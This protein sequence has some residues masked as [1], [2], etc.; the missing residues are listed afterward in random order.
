MFVGRK[1]EI[2]ELKDLLKKKSASFVV[3]KGRRRIGKSR[4]LDEFS[5]GKKTFKFTG[6]APHKSTTKQRQLDE[7]SKQLSAAT[8]L[9]EIKTDEWSK[10][11]ALLAREVKTGRV[12]I[13]FDE[14]S[15][16]GSK[17]PDFLGKLKNAWDEKFKKNAKLIFIVCGSISTWIDENILNN[18]A[19]YGRIS[20]SMNLE[21]LPLSDCNL[22]LEAQGFKGS[23]YE[24]FKVLS[25][26][27]GVPWYIEQIQ[28][29]FNADDNIRR[30]CFTKGGAFVEEFDR[31]FHEIFGK[32]DKV[33]KE[34]IESLL[35]GSV[36]YDEIV[37]K[38]EYRSGGRLSQ[39][40]SDLSN[41]GFISRDYTWS[42]KTGKEIKISRFRLKDNYL[43]FY[44][45]YVS[46][47][48]PQIEKGGFRIASLAS[49]PGWESIMGLQFENL[50]LNNREKI[51]NL[52]KIR[53]EDVV[54]DNPFLQ[55]QTTRQ[56]GCQIAYLVQTKFKN[57]YLCEIKFSRNPV[58]RKVI[59]EIK[60]KIDRLQ[61]P[62]GTSILPVL[63]HVSGVAQSVEESGYFYEIID[64]GELLF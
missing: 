23:V 21:P 29:N 40:L 55:K 17:D 5:K 4:L 39:Y 16:I 31:I 35:N 50:V 34:I 38:A 26:T 27:G 41:A 36:E 10:L 15:W 33:Y 53:L 64:F 32:R 28:G 52:L 48:Y 11:F 14:I 43:R 13:I 22:M 18:T 30:Q 54:A 60:E 61:L 37:K 51:F 8:G 59:E 7:F 56:Q 9:P 49:L 58:S 19:F 44:L 42:L 46:T 24:K 20:W 6:L 62:R 57:L 1:I 2:Q 45:K 47:K 25:V 12:V 63:I 3:V